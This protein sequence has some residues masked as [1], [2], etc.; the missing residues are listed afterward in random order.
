[1]LPC[2]GLKEVV[3]RTVNQFES[4]NDVSCVPEEGS[5]VFTA[6]SLPEH[7]TI[8]LLR[9]DMSHPSGPPLQNVDWALT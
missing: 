1:M 9:S 6:P 7:C 3:I 5:T 8:K 4:Q 2:S